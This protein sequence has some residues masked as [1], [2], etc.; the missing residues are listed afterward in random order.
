[1]LANGRTVGGGAF[2][3]GHIYQML[4]NPIYAGRIRHKQ[5]VHDGL[6]PA[7]VSPEI[8]DI[9]QTM[10][11]DQAGRDRGQDNAAQASPLAGKLF[12]ETGD[13]LTPSHT[14]K[15]GIR[16][17][18]YVSHRLVKESG[19]P[20]PSGWRL[21]A[22]PLEQ[23]I[24]GII[25]DA[26]GGADFLTRMISDLSAAETIRLRDGVAD[27]VKVIAAGDDAAIH[28]AAVLISQVTVAPDRIAV[29]ID[30]AALAS[31]LGFA[32]DRVPDEH[33]ALRRDLRLRRRGVETRLV[34]GE[35]RPEI[36]R[37]LIRNIARARRWLEAA[38]RGQS[39]DEIATQE[40][41]S[42]NRLQQTIH[43]AFLA[44]DIVTDIV[45]GKQPL[46]LTSEWL[47]GRDLPVAWDAQRR[48]IAAL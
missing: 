11:A 32:R 38:Q 41:V 26:F 9:V 3:R 46:G 12:D 14:N 43:L 27:L 24:T 15:K 19:A 5:L 25:A 30:A 48:L 44:P 1:M 18:Y 34:L 31:A 21:P 39:F 33:L 17:R 8:W 7:I 4:S 45:A 29:D 20:D 28:G 2:S 35:P 36:D 22:R 10:L 6:H 16:H 13:R 47:K 23:A 40:D 37:T 42:K